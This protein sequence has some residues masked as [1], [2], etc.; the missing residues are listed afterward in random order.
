MDWLSIKRRFTQHFILCRSLWFRLNAL[1]ITHYGRSVRVL[2]A[3]KYV[4]SKNTIPDSSEAVCSRRLSSSL[5]L[6]TVMLYALFAS[7]DAIHFPYDVDAPLNPQE[8][9]AAQKYCTDAYKK[10]PES[11]GSSECEAKPIQVSEAAARSERIE[12]QVSAF[13]Q[14]SLV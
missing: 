14:N 7:S 13:V 5:Q 11:Q 3:L 12:E 4:N 1:G 6:I 9:E 10:P 8:I 2:E